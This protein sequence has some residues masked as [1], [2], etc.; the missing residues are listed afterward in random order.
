MKNYR[1]VN[2]KF[3]NESRKNYMSLPDLFQD[4][5]T[6]CLIKL[7]PVFRSLKNQMYVM[8][9]IEQRNELEDDLY[10]ELLE[11]CNGI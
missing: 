3:K 10:F 1:G 8:K 2:L 5:T 6:D 9:E 7:L 4:L 11:T